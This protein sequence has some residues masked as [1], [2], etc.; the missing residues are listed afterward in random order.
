MAAPAHE[1]FVVEPVNISTPG[2][3]ET[4]GIAGDDEEFEP[5]TEEVVSEEQAASAQEDVSDDELRAELNEYSKDDLLALAEVHGLTLSKS[6]KKAEIVAEL[7]EL[8]ELD[9]SILDDS[10]S[11]EEPE[12]ETESTSDDLLSF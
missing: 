7:L 10:E 2:V 12:E 8:D 11:G 9:V 6:L 4:L 3:E 1:E 5:I